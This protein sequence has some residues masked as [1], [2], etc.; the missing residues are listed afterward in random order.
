[1][2]FIPEDSLEEI[3]LTATRG[4]TFPIGTGFDFGHWD[5][6]FVLPIGVQAELAVKDAARLSILEPAVI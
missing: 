3:L 6:M 1:V 4:Y 2:G 5:P